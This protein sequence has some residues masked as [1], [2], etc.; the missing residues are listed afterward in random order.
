MKDDKKAPVKKEVNNAP[1]VDIQ[2]LQLKAQC[3]EIDEKIAQ[4][5]E[6]RLQA[7]H[8]LQQYLTKGK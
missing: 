4:L 6:M 8:Q 5:K 7:R 2:L 3:F 1:E